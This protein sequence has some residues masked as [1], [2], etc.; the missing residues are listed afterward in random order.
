[1]SRQLFSLR[2]DRYQ[3]GAEIVEF[4]ITLPVV[5][6]VLAIIVDFGIA[7]CDQAILSN[8]TRSA[9]LEVIRGGTD[10]EAQQAANQISQS[11][12]SRPSSDPFPTVIVQRAGANPGDQIRVTINYTYN[13]FVLPAFLSAVTNLNLSATAVMNMLPT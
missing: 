5:L 13:F 1:M 10:A 2:G 9:V 4:L 3:K 12:I 8:A 6:I 11:M 7:F